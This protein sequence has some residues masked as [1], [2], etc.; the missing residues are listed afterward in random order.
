VSP[1]IKAAFRGL[2]RGLGD[3]FSVQYQ[4]LHD[5]IREQENLNSNG[6]CA[7]IR[8]LNEISSQFEDASPNFAVVLGRR[9][10]SLAAAGSTFFGWMTPFDWFSLSLRFWAGAQ[11]AA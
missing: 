8:S 2:A 1:N 9:L 4:G 5:I 6:L 3:N 11:P 7:L 10:K